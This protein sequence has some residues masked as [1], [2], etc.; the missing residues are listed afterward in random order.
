METQAIVS[1][2]VEVSIVKPEREL[3]AREQAAFECMQDNLGFYIDI[4]K[5]IVELNQTIKVGNE[6]A[7]AGRKAGREDNERR[8][9]WI[10]PFQAGIDNMNADCKVIAEY[11]KTGI[12]HVIAEVFKGEAEVSRRIAVENARIAEENAKA[13]RLEEEANKLQQANAPAG[14]IAA[15]VVIA[16]LA[17]IMAPKPKNRRVTT[18]FNIVKH[19]KLHEDYVIAYLR[20]SGKYEDM[21]KLALG[22]I[23]REAK[24]AKTIDDLKISGIEIVE[25]IDF[26]G[27]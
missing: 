17:P 3:K 23:V 16:K 26:V 10:R 11:R 19:F 9:S 27:R 2:A 8:L 22:E 13:R 21:L 20:K 1:Q 4:S 15:P 18:T 25:K 7:K 14:V 12:D 5:P 24:R 6:V